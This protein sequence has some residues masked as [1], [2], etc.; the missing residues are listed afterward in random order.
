MAFP[1]SQPI[2]LHQHRGEGAAE[3]FAVTRVPVLYKQHLKSLFL[4]LQLSVLVL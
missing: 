1:F 3:L 2:S 4:L